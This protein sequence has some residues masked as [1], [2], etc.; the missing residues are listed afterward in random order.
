MFGI[1]V[2]A[3]GELAP[4]FLET[5]KKILGEECPSAVSFPI[6]WDADFS[7]VKNSL[8]KTLKRMLENHDSVLILT[9]L[10]GGTPTNLA[11]TFYQKSKVEI[12]TGIN[13]PLL[14]KA[15][16][17]QKSGIEMEDALQELRIKA[18]EAIVLVSEVMEGR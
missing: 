8:S 11:M 6:G 2:V 16:L 10:F 4:L 1:L 18:Q 5:A 17:V 14:I 15:L 9:D 13:L 7:A 12:M 3:H